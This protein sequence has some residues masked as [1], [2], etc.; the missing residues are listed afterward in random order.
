VRAQLVL[1]LFLLG[2]SGQPA[3]T[4]AAHAARGQALLERGDFAGAAA[5][6]E[7]LTQLEPDTPRGLIALF[8]THARAAE[9]AGSLDP[10]TADYWIDELGRALGASDGGAALASLR[11]RVDRRGCAPCAHTLALLAARQK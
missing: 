10:G 3:D 6:F 2:C 5:E 1:L 4:P 7:R 9:T 8:Y 11:A